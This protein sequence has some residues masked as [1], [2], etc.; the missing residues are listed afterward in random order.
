MI[1]SRVEWIIAR[2]YL[3]AKRD[4]AFIALTAIFSI[5]GIMLGVATL[6]VVTSVM[7]GVRT[8]MLQHFTGLSGHIYVFPYDRNGLNNYHQL[9]DKIEQIDGV[10]F[11][12][13]V[14]EGQAMLSANSIAVGAQIRAY[15]SSALQSKNYLHD[16]IIAGSW[17]EFIDKQ[18][19]LLLGERLARK[20]G[21]AIGQSVTLISPDGRYTVVGMIPRMQSYRIS[22]IFKFGMHSIDSAVVIMPF[23][24]AQRY[25]KLNDAGKDVVTAIEVHVANIDLAQDIAATIVNKFAD[26]YGISAVDWRMTNAAVFEALNVQRLVMFIILSM[27]ILV[28]AFNIISSLVMLVKDKQRDIA[29]LRSFGVSRLQIQKIFILCGVSIGATGALLGLLLGV[30]L[31][32]NLDAIRIWLESI[33]GHAMLGEQLYFLAALPSRI[34]WKEV[35]AIIAMALLLSVIAAIYPAR[36]AAKMNPAEALRYE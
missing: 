31:A 23:S 30:C 25:F 10:E 22:A 21:L 5:V 1:F 32:V 29:I 4:E 33:T 20:M 7:N 14:I 16:K 8:E 19:G 9:A 36:K 3:W 27:I 11:A 12:I 35:V 17:R 26:E 34:D 24:Q 2:R 6:I 13:P 15:E 18:D 28:A